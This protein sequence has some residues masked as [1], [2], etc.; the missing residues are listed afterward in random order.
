MIEI[1]KIVFLFLV[2]WQLPI[3]VV[4]AARK[5]GVSWLSFLALAIGIT[6]FVYLQ[7]LM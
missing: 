4:R 3:I 2:A 6:G 5:L 7:F 1:L